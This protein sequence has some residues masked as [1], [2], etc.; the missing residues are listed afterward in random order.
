MEV[1]ERAI[2]GC[3]LAALARRVPARATALA[4][5]LG[6]ALDAKDR[7]ARTLAERIPPALC[8][9]PLLHKSDS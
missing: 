9:P 1:S 3:E 4:L 7:G 8:P 6:A 2:R 5:D